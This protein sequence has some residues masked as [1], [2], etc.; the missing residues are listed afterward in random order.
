MTFVTPEDKAAHRTAVEKYLRLISQ[1]EEQRLC[2]K[3]SKPM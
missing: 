3:L 1:A 2:R